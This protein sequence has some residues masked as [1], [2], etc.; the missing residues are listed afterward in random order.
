MSNDN[1]AQRNYRRRRF[2][3]A[4]GAGTMATAAGCLGGGSEAETIP[5]GINADLSGPTS[6]I[7]EGGTGIEY[8]LDGYV[9]EN[10]NGLDGNGEYVFDTVVRDGEESAEA[11]RNA[12]NFYRD[13]HN[14]VLVQ[15]WATPANVAL[16][17]QI[18]A[19]GLPHFGQ[20]KSEAWGTQNEFMHLFGPSY[21]DYFRIM[22]DW[23]KEN[24][25]DNIAILYSVFLAPTVERLLEERRY[26]DMIDVNIV[27]SIQHDFA[28]DDL[29]PQVE[30]INENDFDFLIHGNVVEGAVPAISA[31]NDVG[32]AHDKYCTYNWSTIDGLFDVTD[33]T[34]GI[35]GIIEN[36]TGYP[37]DVPAT[38]EIDWYRENVEEISE[39]ERQ[40][41]L[42]N[43]WAK[44]KFIEHI[45]RIAKDELEPQGDLPTD[46]TQE[47]RS[48]FLEA[49]QQVSGL[50]TGCGIPEIDYTEA[51][52]KGFRGAGVYQA[53]GG[54]WNEL[55]VRTPEHP[56]EG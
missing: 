4:V 45:A 28:P 23:A 31:I 10:K 40:A 16:S 53:S 49:W 9:N 13:R 24:K 3:K 2:L 25:G 33:D 41:Y 48:L 39:D 15:L 46:D 27:S 14:A 30:S 21:E 17:D 42:Y 55:E 44:G 52:L 29:T 37:S 1:V 34:D 54:E 47:M 18:E 19:A 6:F 56:F 43:G 8:Y 38:E 7:S 22:M 50:D 35:Y 20:S 51:P 32:I 12:L 5:I 11:E 36:P 26:Q